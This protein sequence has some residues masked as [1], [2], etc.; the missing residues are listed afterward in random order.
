MMAPSL[1]DMNLMDFQQM[2]RA[3]LSEK[4]AVSTYNSSTYRNEKTGFPPRWGTNDQ[5]LSMFSVFSLTTEQAITSINPSTSSLVFHS[6]TPVFHDNFVY[7]P[8]PNSCVGTYAGTV[9]GMA[10]CFGRG[11]D[12]EKGSG[13]HEL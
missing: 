8:K 3:F 7:G 2:K 5:M 1:E 10:K 13:C 9:A 4:N 11:L 12:V 6:V